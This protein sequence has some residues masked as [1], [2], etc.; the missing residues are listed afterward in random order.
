M[1]W[2]EKYIKE[3]KKFDYV[4]GDLTDIPISDTPTGEVWNFIRTI[5][6]KSFKILKKNG[7]YF[8]HGNGANCVE[9]LR[10]FEEQLE[11]LVPAVKYTKSNAFVPSFMEDWVFYQVIEADV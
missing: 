8:T 11:K 3:G 2:L 9:S 7:K 10:M 6:E 5:L 4:F 1:V